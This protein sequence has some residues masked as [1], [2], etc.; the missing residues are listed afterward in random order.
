M[1]PTA[2]VIGGTGPTGPPLALGLQ[3]RGFD[4]TL[5]HSGR[6]ELAEVAHF[7]HL[8][9]DV[10]NEDSL[11][12]ILNDERFDV[13]V[14]SYGRLR[15]I[16]E[17]LVGKVGRMISIGGVPAYRGYFDPALHNPAGLPVPTNESADTSTEDEDAKSYRIRRTEEMVFEHHP[18]ATHFRYPWVYGPRQIAPREWSIVRRIQD[19]RPFLILPDDG[20]ALITFGYTE[21]LAHALLCAV[22]HPVESMGEIFNCGD[23]ECLTV[24]QVVEIV[25]DELGH[26]FE[27]ISMPGHLAIPARPLMM[28]YMNTHRVLDTSKLQTR[29]GYRDVVPARQALRLTARWLAENPHTPG[30]VAEIAIEDPFDY[31]AEDRLVAWWR[32]AV[33]APPQLDYAVEPGFGK[34]Y[35]GPGTNYVRSDKRI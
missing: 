23:D 35:A 9:A 3:A 32:A 6:H 22:D 13:A 5:L 12:A 15:S 17:V 29:L 11:A 16:A 1:K 26:G 30:S 20:L 4:V 28:S 25:A 31:A 27:L 10:Y 24:R 2:L 14:A 18:T 8:H 33:G 7:R 34:G 19:K 21:N